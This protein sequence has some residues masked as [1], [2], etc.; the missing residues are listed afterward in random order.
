MRGNIA[1]KFVHFAHAQVFVFTVTNVAANFTSLS[2][3]IGSRTG[4]FGITAKRIAT[5][6]LYTYKGYP[7]S[8][9]EWT[10]AE[11]TKVSLLLVKTI[12]AI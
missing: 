9:T 10:M 3:K 7:F 11:W 8:S 5:L 6:K 12:R 1:F 2:N 4:F